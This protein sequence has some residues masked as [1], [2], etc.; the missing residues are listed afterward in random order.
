M[1]GTAALAIPSGTLLTGKLFQ[2]PAQLGHSHGLGFLRG[3]GAVQSG[4]LHIHPVLAQGQPGFQS[5]VP[6]LQAGPLALDVP[7]PCGFLFHLAEDAL[8]LGFISPGHSQG[9]GGSRGVDHI[10]LQQ[11]LHHILIAPEPGLEGLGQGFPIGVVGIHPHHGA[12]PVD[13]QLQRGVYID[14]EVGGGGQVHPASRP[15]QEHQ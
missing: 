12:E 10:Q 7:A 6:F 13:A 3:K 15:Q 1:A 8:A 4:D 5:L 9:E 11:L 2:F 14:A